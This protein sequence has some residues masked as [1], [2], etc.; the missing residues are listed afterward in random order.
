MARSF[1]IFASLPAAFLAGACGRAD[2]PEPDPVELER[3]LAEIEAREDARSATFHEKLAK[4]DR[5]S[6]TLV[7]VEPEK[8]EAT[9]ATAIVH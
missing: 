6:S 5:I 3:A 2:E 8:L 9:L 1:S 4:V 7:R